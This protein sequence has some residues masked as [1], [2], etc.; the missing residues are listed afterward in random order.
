MTTLDERKKLLVQKRLCCNCT[1]SKHRT[2]ECKSN[3]NCQKCNL[4]HHTSICNKETSFLGTAAG[5]SEGPVVYPVVVVDKPKLSVH[6]ILGASEYTRIKTGERPRVGETGEP[7]AKKTK[8][9]WTIIARERR[10]TTPPC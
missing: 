3:I 8:F 5:T 10:S 9:G 2:S 4:K 7:V 6:L 1:G